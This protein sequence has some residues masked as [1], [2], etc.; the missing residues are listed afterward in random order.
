MDAVQVRTDPREG[1]GH[2]HKHGLRRAFHWGMKETCV[3]PKDWWVN[4]GPALT[5]PLRFG[6][7]SVRLSGV[8][9]H[10]QQLGWRKLLRGAVSP[11]ERT[12]VQFCMFYFPKAFFFLSKTVC[13]LVLCT[14]FQGHFKYLYILLS[15]RDHILHFKP[16]HI[17]VFIIYFVC[18]LN[19]LHTKKVMI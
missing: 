19:S 7:V 2:K 5:A 10:Q 18:F 3:P 1:P 14:W 13:Y 12:S 17:R 11:Q 8:D 6:K 16:R 4:T 9:A 15:T